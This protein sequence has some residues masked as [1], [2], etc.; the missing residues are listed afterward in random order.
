VDQDKAG[1]VL[2][3][4]LDEDGGTRSVSVEE[5]VVGRTRFETLS[6]DAAT[7]GSQP[8]LIARLT[9]KAD[10][11]LV[12]LV[13]IDGVRPDELDVDV[14]E[15][16]TALRG[17]FLGL[18]VR[19]RSTPPLTDGPL[20]SPETIAG[21]FIRDLEERIS[22]AETEG[23]PDEAVDLREALRLGRLLLAGHEVTL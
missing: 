2:L 15:V 7:I 23:R 4:T 14:G 11:D 17:S 20:P 21:T 9:A 10:P 8:D 12:L 6:V 16:E 18:R 13:V 1:K 19:D 3:V 5:R 22:A